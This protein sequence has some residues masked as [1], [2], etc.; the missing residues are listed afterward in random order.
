MSP[1]MPIKWAFVDLGERQEL[2]AELEANWVQWMLSHPGWKLRRGEGRVLQRGADGHMGRRAMVISEPGR[3]VFVKDL[4]HLDG[5]THYQGLACDWQL[6]VDGVHVTQGGH[7]AW[8]EAGEKWCSMHT[9]CR[10]GGHF[11]DVDA[12]HISILTPEGVA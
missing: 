4:V 10:W 7:P 12:N 2:F 6:F 1:P 9:L 11:S 5:G 8:R 3:V